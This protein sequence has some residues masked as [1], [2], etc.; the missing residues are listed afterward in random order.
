MFHFKIIKSSN[1]SSTISPSLSSTHTSQLNSGILI[2]SIEIFK[3]ILFTLFMLVFKASRERSYLK[4]YRTEEAIEENSQKLIFLNVEQKIKLISRGWIQVFVTFQMIVMWDFVV[5]SEYLAC[6]GVVY[7][8]NKRLTL[9][10][11]RE[12]VKSSIYHRFSFI[13]D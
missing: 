7:L 5:C 13:I 6:V 1:F 12:E 9:S 10:W 4:N 8:F 11:A 2:I 3:L